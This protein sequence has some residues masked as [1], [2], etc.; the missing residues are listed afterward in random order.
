V[1]GTV[2]VAGPEPIALDKLAG[3][4]MAANG[5]GRRV[6]ADIHALYFGSVLNDQ[7][8]TPGRN[9]RIGSTRFEDWRA[10]GAASA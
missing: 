5:D 3:E 7:S 1:N 9:P 6:V 4:V 10:G 2:E 8:L